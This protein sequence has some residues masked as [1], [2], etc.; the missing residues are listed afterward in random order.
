MRI[1]FAV[2]VFSVLM[3]I[4]K[5]AHSQVDAAG[6]FL[7]IGAIRQGLNEALVGIQNATVTAGSEG[8]SLG[9]S[10]QANIQNVIA[11]IDSRFGNRLDSTF[12]KLDKTERQFATDA[13]DLIFRSKSAMIS[14]TGAIG[15]ESRRTIGEADIAAYNTSF[16]LPCRSQVPRVVYWTPTSTAAKGEEIIVSIHGNFLNLGN[17]LKILVGGTA[18]L[19]VTRSD[20]IISVR[21]TREIVQK[22]ADKS[23]VSIVISGLQKRMQEPWFLSWIFGCKEKME[24]VQDN[25]I[26]VDLIPRLSYQV[27]TEVWA[28]YSEWSEP[29]VYRHERLNRSDNNC[30]H[31]ENISFSICLPPDLRAVRGQF[32]V[33]SRSD[34][35][36]F[37]PAVASGQNCILFN[38]RL[39]GCGYHDYIVAHDCICHAWLDVDWEVIA[40]RHDTMETARLRRTDVLPSG[41]YS[42]AVDNAQPPMGED[43]H[44]HYVARIT[45]MRGSQSLAS[46]TLTDGRPDNG[47][48]WMSTMRDGVLTVSLPSGA[49]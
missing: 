17:N 13:R 46:E 30:N 25:S 44:W 6:S 16:S 31:N 24:T 4:G 5:T 26:V 7:T 37:G 39:K 28:T 23:S 34:P 29:F 41:Q 18:T 48:G 47:Q 43:W 27:E 3:I 15:E 20:R 42:H 2:F 35:S 1:Y 8:R 10:L 45:Q 36:S 12:D 40:Q 19:P 32:S 9:N 21:L 14:L 49:E 22:V 33:H 38:A 11:D